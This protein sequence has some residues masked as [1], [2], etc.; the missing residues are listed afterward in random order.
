MHCH[1]FLDE[2]LGSIWKVYLHNFVVLLL[3]L[4]T[5]WAIIF[6]IS[7]IS[8]SEQSALR[9][10]VCSE[11]IWNTKCSLFKEIT[12]TVSNNTISFHLTETETTTTRTTMCR[13][14]N[15]SYN[16]SSW[17]RIHL[18]IDQMSESLIEGG[19]EVDLCCETHACIWIVK[20]FVSVSLITVCVQFWSNILKL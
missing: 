20:H 16:R 19:P 7:E 17:S 8:F 10:Y 6:M 4:R 11:L 3:I 5:A 13:L 1:K 14:T 12:S 2:L 15:N 9:T 18:I